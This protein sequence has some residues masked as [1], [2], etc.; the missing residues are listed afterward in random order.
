[1]D[2]PNPACQMLTPLKCVQFDIQRQW[3]T[4]SDSTVTKV[5]VIFMNLPSAAGLLLP[6]CQMTV[7]LPKAHLVC[8][9]DLKVLHML[10]HKNHC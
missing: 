9:L 10:N 4:S 2:S 3:L 5:E 8:T 7:W 6:D 1:M